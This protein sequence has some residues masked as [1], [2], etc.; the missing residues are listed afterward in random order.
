MDSDG[1]PQPCP[2][3][4]YRDV[5]TLQEVFHELRTRWATTAPA[6]DGDAWQQVLT[7]AFAAVPV[8]ART[9]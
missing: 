6:D 4:A 9:A 8:T 5:R 1:R 7:G 2:P 3:E